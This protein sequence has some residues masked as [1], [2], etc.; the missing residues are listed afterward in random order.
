MIFLE[1]N[2]DRWISEQEIKNE[3]FSMYP[4]SDIGALKKYLKDTIDVADVWNN[5][6]R[7]VEYRF[8]IWREGEREKYLA[9]LEWF[10]MLK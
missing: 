10:N 9:D 6:T 2:K 8:V 1:K 7:E 3:A 5:E 4:K